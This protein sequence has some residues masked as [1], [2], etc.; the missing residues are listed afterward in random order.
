MSNPFWPPEAALNTEYPSAH[1]ARTEPSLS[2]NTPA[3]LALIWVLSCC[4]EFHYGKLR[5]SE[6]AAY[7]RV[8]CRS[9]AHLKK[10]SDAFSR[11][12][13]VGALDAYFHHVFRYRDAFW[14]EMCTF[15][16]LALKSV[17][18]ISELT[19]LTL[20]N[21]LMHQLWQL[22]STFLSVFFWYENEITKL[23]SIVQ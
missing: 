6:R 16:W 13:A 8:F 18:R 23:F 1:T 2:T 4:V 11:F 5:F 20:M 10:E 19:Q 14:Y 12:S 3:H 7:I 15:S 21:P 22:V 17:L 9:C